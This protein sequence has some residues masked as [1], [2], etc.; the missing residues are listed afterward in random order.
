[1]GRLKTARL[2]LQPDKCQ[3]LC[4]EI[5]YLGHIITREGVKP[6][7]KKVEAVRCFP[8]PKCRKNV[9]QFLG[10]AGYYRRFIPNLASSAK[11]LTSLLKKNV[12]FTWTEAAERAFETLKNVLCTQPLLQYPDF[13]KPFI[14]T[15]DASDLAVGAILSQGEIGKDLPIAYASRTLSRAE[16][17][18]N[19]TEKEL[20]AIIFAVKHFR[21]YIYG[22][23]FSLITDHRSLV[24]LDK[25][26][27]PTMGS[28]LARWKIKLQ[29]YDYDIKYKP[30]R[31]NANADALSRNPVDFKE[32]RSSKADAN[33]GDCHDDAITNLGSNIGCSTEGKVLYHEYPIERV[34]VTTCETDDR[35]MDDTESFGNI[36]REMTNS[37]VTEIDINGETDE[38]E[39]ASVNLMGNDA[40]MTID[41]GEVVSSIPK[42]NSS[43][44]GS[45]Q[46]GEETEPSMLASEGCELVR[47]VIPVPDS[48]KGHEG[49]PGAGCDGAI[50]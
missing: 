19:T 25:L 34:L 11:P 14:I 31:V 42:P 6:D 29:E 49:V 26:K 43:R 35:D 37:K 38:K 2:V 1:M 44:G 4:K 39:K 18:Y 3:F 8:R 30:G 16:L 41:S 33:G 32:V 48:L 10:L 36:Y 12:P 47:R 45:R 7:P 46:G 22:Q 21:P 50:R 17:N 9:K 24:W 23:K 15:T 13:S 40:P 20:L 27:D 28:R 5:G